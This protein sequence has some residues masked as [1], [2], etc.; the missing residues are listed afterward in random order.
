M[1]EFLL[2]I[3]GSDGF[4]LRRR[5]RIE[6]WCK[7]FVQFTRDEVQPLLQTHAF[8]RAIRRCKLRRGR[9]I[10]DVLHDHRPLSNS[11]AVVEF[12]HRHGALRIDRVEI[13]AVVKLVRLRARAH[14]I[15]WQ[16]CFTQRDV[17]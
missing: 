4:V 10:G 5:F 8:K 16:S 14:E 3:F 11:L 9:E 12:E 13:C 7:S 2:Q 17:R 6:Q 1:R 15:K